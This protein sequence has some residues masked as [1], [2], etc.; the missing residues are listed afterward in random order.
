MSD[1][2]GIKIELGPFGSGDGHGIFLADGRDILPEILPKRIVIECAAGELTKA[3]IETDITKSVVVELMP[4]CVSV[5]TFGDEPETRKVIA[6][7]HRATELLLEYEDD[8]RSP[9]YYAGIAAALD[10][11]R[12]YVL[13]FGAMEKEETTEL[14]GSRK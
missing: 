1:E 4:E 11:I 10:V 12:P 8:S 14:E 3:R 7:I 2:I 13:M 5:T 6:E 9:E